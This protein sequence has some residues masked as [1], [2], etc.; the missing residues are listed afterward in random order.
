M[1][2][3]ITGTIR[4][5]IV[6]VDRSINPRAALGFFFKTVRLSSQNR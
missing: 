4:D 2:F 6:N 5:P 1:K 3:R